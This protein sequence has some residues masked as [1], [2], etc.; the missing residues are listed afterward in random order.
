ML[1]PLKQLFDYT[2]ARDVAAGGSTTITFEITA[3]D[4]AEVDEQTGDLVSEA[5]SYTLMF[6]DGGGQ[7]VNMTAVV[8]GA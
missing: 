2:R 7:V 6:D 8:K 4:L 3:A 5:A 1:T